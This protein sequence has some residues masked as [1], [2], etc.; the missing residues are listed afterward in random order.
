MTVASCAA[1]RFTFAGP[2]SAFTSTALCSAMVLAASFC[3]TSI[4]L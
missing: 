2:C 3:L 1:A 4:F